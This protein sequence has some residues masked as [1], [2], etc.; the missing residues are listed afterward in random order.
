MAPALE[1]VEVTRMVTPTFTPTRRTYPTCAGFGSN[2]C[3]HIVADNVSLSTLA[4]IYLRDVCRWPQISNA[5]RESDGMY[6]RMRTGQALFIPEKPA[7]YPPSVLV[8]PGVTAPI[9]DCEF[10]QNGVLLSAFPCMYEIPADRPMYEFGYGEVASRLYGTTTLGDYI[11]A[12]N[13]AS[14]CSTT[15]TAEEAPLPVYLEPGVRIVV[16]RRPPQ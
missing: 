9:G 15:G 8:Q 6:P 14:G 2:P 5:N 1:T 7:L 12:A 11:A 16:P 3:I 4:D 10:D 13:L